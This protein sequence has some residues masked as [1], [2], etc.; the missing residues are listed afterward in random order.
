MVRPEPAL[1][2]AARGWVCVRVTDMRG[3]DL[4][5]FA[6]DYDLTLA[7]LLMHWD[8]TVWHR[9]GG[10]D[11]RSPTAWMSVPLLVRLLDDT[12]AE[13]GAH[14]P[15]D[16]TPGARRT[17]DDYPAFRS[18]LAEGRIDCV[19]CHMVHDAWHASARAAGT[20]RKDDLWIWPEPERIGV[21]LDGD[22]PA[23]IA[24]VAGESA[25]A[26]AGLAAGDRL[27]RV[28]DQLVRTFADLQWVLHRAAAGATRLAVSH[29]RDGE[30]HRT[31][32]ELGDGWKAGTP[33]SFSWRALKWNLEPEPGFG[34][35][36]LD[37]ARRKELGLAP[38]A[39]AFRIDYL[40]TWGPKARTGEAARRAGLRKG[41]VV[42]AIDGRSDFASVDHFHAWV[43][44]ERAVGDR[45]AVRTLRDGETREV[46]VE[47]V[48]GR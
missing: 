44:L 35:P 28:G 5:R 31:Q 21:T 15:I 7:A 11:H 36:L 42:V 47:L 32:L 16:A 26:R 4:D 1:I 9:F 27:E 3:V 45:I 6:F 37:A 18:K 39:F 33:L 10:R 24:S 48:G 40:V 41:D 22:D 17:V 46:E 25:A 14:Q 8:G 23:R 20:W 34:G 19:H 2:E 43:R 30:L 29:H 13:H 12:L 38:D